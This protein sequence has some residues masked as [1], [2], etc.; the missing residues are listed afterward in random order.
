MDANFIFSLLSVPLYEYV[1][2]KRNR[3]TWI[4]RGMPKLADWRRE[5]ARYTGRTQG[6]LLDEHLAV[7]EPGDLDLAELASY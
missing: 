3:E 5:L 4:W 2:M 1:R 6:C 7:E